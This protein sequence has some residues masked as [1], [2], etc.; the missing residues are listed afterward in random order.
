M[1]CEARA[2]Y[3]LTV[4]SNAHG[5]LGKAFCLEG[6]ALRVDTFAQLY[7]GRARRVE[8][9]SLKAFAAGR[10]KLKPSQAL[11]Y[12]VT[13]HS[14][15]DIVT[16][17]Q[18]RPDTIARDRAH[19]RWPEGPGIW[20][21]DHDGVGYDWQQ[22]DEIFAGCLPE[23][24]AAGRYWTPSNSAFI[25]ERGG[26]TLIGRGGWRCYVAVDHAP[27]I[28]RLTDAL[29]QALVAAGHGAPLV[30]ASGQVHIKTLIDRTVA[31]P[32]RL[33]FCT[34]TLAPELE[35][36]GESRLI[37]GEGLVSAYVG[38][39]D[40]FR[41]I[42]HNPIVRR[43]KDSAQDEARRNAAQWETAKIAEDIA[44]GVDPERARR[45]WRRVSGECRALPH[46]FEIELTNGAPVTVADILDNPAAY[47]RAR[48][49]DPLEPEYRNDNRI[50]I[51][52]PRTRMI[53]SWAHGGIKYRL[54][55]PLD[56]ESLLDEI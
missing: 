21:I 37:A 22:L 39:E 30:T 8:T 2:L 28:P 32:E 41:W 4:V 53:F 9:K 16:Q 40:H 54:L 46:D 13:E 52:Y 17:G 31:Q 10:A 11:C 33:D 25:R 19:F 12:G 36:F 26:K 29:F 48:C 43:L 51:I 5:P 20:F 27:R 6:G 1:K 49:A 34:P 44:A 23:F 50:A 24:S 14:A 42:E 18:A 7:E 56:T 55:S 38:A 15:V 45:K 35:R 47:E 3:S